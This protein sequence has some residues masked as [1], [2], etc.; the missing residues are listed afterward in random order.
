MYSHTVYIQ[1][2]SKNSSSLAIMGDNGSQEV[3]PQQ[4]VGTESVKRSEMCIGLNCATRT[5]LDD[6]IIISIRITRSATNPTLN[7]TELVTITQS[8]YIHIAIIIIYTSYC[9]YSYTRN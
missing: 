7:R 1:V 9:T 6:G 2:E 4:E 5:L 8:M 3:I